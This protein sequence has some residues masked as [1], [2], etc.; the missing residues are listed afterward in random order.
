MLSSYLGAGIMLF[1]ATSIAVGMVV[2]TS[3]LGP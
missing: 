1:M 2:M 3:I